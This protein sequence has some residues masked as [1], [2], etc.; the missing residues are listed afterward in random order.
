MFQRTYYPELKTL[1]VVLIIMLKSNWLFSQQAELFASPV[2]PGETQTYLLAFADNLCLPGSDAEWTITN[3]SI[4]G[5][6]NT[7]TF[8]RT[9]YPNHSITITW[10]N[11]RLSGSISV[12]LYT[13][14][15]SCGVNVYPVSATVSKILPPEP[16]AISF[17]KNNVC[18]GEVI[19]LTSVAPNSPYS[20]QFA[21]EINI[22]NGGWVPLTSSSS[23]TINFT[24]PSIALGT[25]DY[26]RIK[27]RFYTLSTVCSGL[28][29][30]NTIQTG[31]LFAYPPAPT[32]TLTPENKV[33]TN[34]ATGGLRITSPT[35]YYT[36]AKININGS[37]NTNLVIPSSLLNN[38]L[39]SLPPGT[40]NIQI[41][42]YSSSD[43][44]AEQCSSPTLGSFTIGTT[45]TPISVSAAVTSNYN[46]RAVTCNNSADGQVTLTPSGGTAP[47]S[48][49]RDGTNFQ[50]ATFNDL[51][52]SPTSYTFTIKDA[53]GC[54]NTT[55][56]ITL[57]NTPDL[58]LG[59]LSPSNYNGF[60]IKCAGDSNG[61]ISFSSGTTGGTGG[62][63][64]V[65]KNS[66][67]A[68]VGT[69]AT[70]SGMPAGSYTVTVTDANNCSKT[71]G[72][73]SLAP[74]SPAL[75]AA[76]SSGSNPVCNGSPGQITAGLGSGGI[77]N[78]PYQYSIDG[79]SFQTSN[80]F[81]I[82]TAIPGS[83]SYA[84]TVK[85]DNGCSAT[86]G[87]VTIT[88]PPAVTITNAPFTS[89][90]CNGGNNGSITVNAS[91]ATQYSKDNGANFQAS[92]VF[93]AL[94]A[95]TYLI[96]A[97]DAAGCTSVATGVIVTQPDAVSGTI[98]QTA[99]IN[100][101]GKS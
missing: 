69:S 81:P 36:E 37:V 10:E 52:P 43:P 27:F 44:N 75:S 57:P 76:P 28:R 54:T 66:S 4:V 2:C 29:S 47:F 65:W 89:P 56:P 39:I 98:T 50:G 59:S 19:S 15:G 1:I 21:W 87:S 68:T 31:D 79:N 18:P 9:F 70:L 30:A 74:P 32:A 41:V 42:N 97:K 84:V 92:N 99:P 62:Y 86:A 71:S 22:N 53:N 46:G 45:N 16:Q 13:S 77:T 73:I 55:L 85:D 67:S 96:V 82:L 93:P 78:K 83:Y 7:S 60:G 58:V 26:H 95:G 35:T 100:C 40:Y 34:T 12:N 33:C 64:Y 5:S 101:N 14:A 48:Y 11:D 91:T 61:Q 3:G 23:S 94:T 20:F 51:S 8:T 63:S 17:S 49:S 72:A 24:V 80:I 38:Y 6:T 90:T 88:I 25:S